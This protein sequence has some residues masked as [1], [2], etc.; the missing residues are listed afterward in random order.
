MKNIQ[1]YYIKIEVYSDGKA[2]V[3]YNN[4][5]KLDYCYNKLTLEKCIEDKGRFSDEEI[6]Y[7]SFIKNRYK[8]Y[9]LRLN[10][11]ERENYVEFDINLN[12]SPV[13][14]Y[15]NICE[16]LSHIK[17]ENTIKNMKKTKIEAEEHYMRLVDN[18]TLELKTFIS[19]NEDFNNAFYKYYGYIKS[20][21]T[22][23]FILLKFY[24]RFKYNACYV[25]SNIRI[26]EQQYY[27][28]KLNDL[29]K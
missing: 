5:K 29:L 26:M 27:K 4:Q 23:N 19:S 9:T 21:F 2:L 15:F 11:I 7:N 24:N 17:I 8:L 12:D 20:K 6:G 3:T 13:D 14:I 1:Y 18:T 10:V 28:Y 22:P 25:P 16:N